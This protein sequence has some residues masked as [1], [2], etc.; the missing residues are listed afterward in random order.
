MAVLISFI[1]LESPG[2]SWC[3]WIRWLWTGATADSLR[4]FPSSMTTV[5]IFIGFIAETVSSAAWPH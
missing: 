5:A 4:V 2:L 1:M 3:S